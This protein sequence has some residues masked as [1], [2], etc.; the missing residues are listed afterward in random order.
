M[1]IFMK[2][3]GILLLVFAALSQ[4]V[5]AEEWKNKTSSPPFEFGVITGA[6]LFGSSVGWGI[7]G[8]A[9]YLIVPDGWIEDIDERVWVEGFFGPAIF[10]EGRTETA[11]QFSTHLRWDFTKNTEWTFYAVGGAGGFFL[12][13]IYG[14]AFTIHPRF[15]VGTEFQT[16]SPVVLRAEVTSDF[17]GVGAG[18][19]F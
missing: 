16:K 1:N 18:L 19:N 14:N 5:S 12:P 13:S 9:A 10:S 2:K 17:I 3:F 6:S 11:L 4:P 8:T 15:G 7:L